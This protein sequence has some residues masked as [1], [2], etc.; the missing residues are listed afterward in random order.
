MNMLYSDANGVIKKAAVPSGGSGTVTSVATGFG[1][2]GGTITTTGTLIVD[3]ASVATRARVQK[4]IDS[5][6]SLTS[7]KVGGTGISGYFPKWTG[8]ATQDTSQLF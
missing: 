2:S 3:S 7:A 4:G 5:V 1:L 8:T 6:A